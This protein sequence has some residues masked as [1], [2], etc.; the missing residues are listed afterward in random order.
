MVLSDYPAHCMGG[1]R[2]LF[3]VLDNLAPHIEIPDSGDPDEG[4]SNATEGR[5]GFRWI[6]RLHDAVARTQKAD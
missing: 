5:R 1:W 2:A 3:C 4:I 6:C